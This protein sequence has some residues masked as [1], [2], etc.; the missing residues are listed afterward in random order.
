M[1]DSTHSVRIDKWLWA[2]R[3][4]KTRGLAVD[5]IKQGRVHCNRDR[6]K[7]SRMLHVGDQLRVEKS[8]MVFE[9]EVIALSDQRGPAS[10]AQTLYQESAESKR[11][12]EVKSAERRA[13]RLS[14]PLPPQTRP[15]KHA[16][17]RIR[18][19]LGK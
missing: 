2:A 19:L 5:A 17:Q 4:F 15:D 9:F 11:Q 7:P 1:N 14:A 13:Q 16:R 18:R 10:V 12:R 6:P 8:G 3:F